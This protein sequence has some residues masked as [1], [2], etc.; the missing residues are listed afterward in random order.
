[1]ATLYTEAEYAKLTPA[2]KAEVRRTGKRL[3]SSG[4]ATVAPPINPLSA[5]AGASKLFAPQYV[6]QS[7]P[8][9][10]GNWALDLQGAVNTDVTN[11]Q[12]EDARWQSEPEQLDQIYN[13]WNK[14]TTS[15]DLNWYNGER[16]QNLQRAGNQSTWEQG[17]QQNIDQLGTLYG[18]AEANN[19]R[20]TQ[21]QGAE[22]DYYNASDSA[23]LGTFQQA[24]QQYASQNNA[25]LGQYNSRANDLY[26]SNVAPVQAAQWQSSGQDLS[27]QNQALGNFNNIYGGGL[28]YTADNWQSNAADVGR[29]QGVYN[30]FQD[31]YGGSLDYQAAQASTNAYDYGNQDAARQQLAD[32][33][34]GSLDWES[35]AAQ[36]FADPEMVRRQ[37]DQY[38][39]LDAISDGSLDAHADPETIAKQKQGL[40]EMGEVRDKYQS[41]SDPEI[42]AQERFIMENLN[43][44]VDDQERVSREAT[45]SDL[46]ARGLRSGAAEQTAMAQSREQAGRNSVLSALG[47]QANA[48]QRSQENLA[49]WANTS[50]AY[51]G[52]AGNM[53]GQEFGE[54]NANYDRRLQGTGMAANQINGMRTAD[55]SE[56]YAR[57]VGADNASEANQGTRLAGSQS[58]YGAAAQMRQQSDNMSMFNTGETN[59]A[60]ANNQATR[61]GGLQGAGTMATNMRNASDNVGMF[62]TGQNNTAYANNQQTRLSGAQGYATQANTIRSNNDAVGTFNTGQT[63]IVGMSNQ[64]MAQNE[65]IRKQGVN[66]EQSGENT[67][68][69]GINYGVAG[70][71]YNASREVNGTNYLRD[72]E[73]NT[74]DRQDVIDMVGR[75]ESL[76]AAEQFLTDGT[77]T[78]RDSVIDAEQD[79]GR[80]RQ[81]VFTGTAA[82]RAANGGSIVANKR[83]MRSAGALNG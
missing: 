17:T 66:Y 45:M 81:T 22:R 23:A 43:Q 1:M 35:Q 40:A 38:G 71:S 21:R 37:W 18:G 34:N 44:Q 2:Q 53:R 77:R 3:P 68:V 78:G 27:N 32:I 20:I 82:N 9:A 29:Q 57:G 10:T 65:L 76:T 8:P 52:Q 6:P 51:T 69:N 79:T 72:Q 47:A 70:D 24:G 12:G 5:E 14:E 33:G 28:D 26:N 54:M 67:R 56:K 19:Q 64:Q 58:S 63:N 61:F 73:F 16:Q 83:L 75:G 49:G 62:N 55:F 50:D 36:A 7:A 4:A 31:V 41:L 11:L 13:D 74:S 30:Q 60:Y 42:T 15:E 80:Q 48:V 59:T 46:G 39:K 25:S